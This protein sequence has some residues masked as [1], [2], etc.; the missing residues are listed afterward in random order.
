M[1]GTSPPCMAAC[2]HM[3]CVA[4]AQS[5]V[6]RVLRPLAAVRCLAKMES[7]RRSCF[8]HGRCTIVQSTMIVAE[9]HLL[10]ETPPP[11][12]G[13]CAAQTSWDS[14]RSWPADSSSSSKSTSVKSG[15]PTTSEHPA[16]GRLAV[17]PHHSHVTR[18]QTFVAALSRSAFSQQN[19]SL[20]GRC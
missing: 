7:L 13:V 9:N 2:Q 14:R 4:L 1:H 11:P 3:C 19:R 20:L 10:C 18:A 12:P 8:C 15:G 5:L 6:H 16:P 17:L